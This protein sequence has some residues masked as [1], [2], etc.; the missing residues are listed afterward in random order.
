MT[1][2]ANV[3]KAP[4]RYEDEYP[5]EAGVLMQICAKNQAKR[6]KGKRIKTL[7]LDVTEPIRKT[8]EFMYTLPD[9]IR[10]KTTTPCKTIRTLPK[11]GRNEKCPCG[12]GKK[13]KK[14][15]IMKE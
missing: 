3:G 8:I 11:V 6:L 12:S 15:C 4:P 1:S 13:F 7:Y 2:V 5:E 14:C 10:R 9:H